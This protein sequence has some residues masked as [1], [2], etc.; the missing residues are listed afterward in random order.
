MKSRKLLSIIMSIVLVVGLTPLPAFAATDSYEAVG[1]SPDFVAQS[2]QQIEEQ[3]E[4]N[5]IEA[6]GATD[7]AAASA[8]DMKLDEPVSGTWGTCPWTIDTEGTLTIH[9]GTGENVPVVGYT[10]G[11]L[12]EA[13]WKKYAPYII[14]VVLKEESGQKVVLPEVCGSLFSWGTGTLGSES[15]NYTLK[16]VDLRGADF[17]GVKS[18]YE[19]F[20]CDEALETITFGADLNTQN[21]QNMERAFRCC[22]S[23]SAIDLSHFNTANVTN[24]YRMFQQCDLLTSLDL[25]GFNMTSA[26]KI[27]D[28]FGSCYALQTLKLS[29]QC[30]LKIDTKT[31]GLPDI[32]GSGDYTGQWQYEGGGYPLTPAQFMDQF[33]PTTKAGTWTW[34]VA[35]DNTRSGVWGTCP[36]NIDAQ[37]TLTVHPG[38]GADTEKCPWLAFKGL[39]KKVVLA[40]ESGNKVVLPANCSS[41]FAFGGNFNGKAYG[42]NVEEID[43]SGA[44]SSQVTNMSTMFGA[45]NSKLTSITFPATWDTSHVTNMAS[46]FMADSA[47][48]SIDLSR[49]DTSSVKDMGHMFSSCSNLTSLDLSGFN[50]SNVAD[51]NSMFFSCGALKSITLSNSWDTSHVTNM[52]S[53]FNFCHSLNSIDFSRFNTSSVTNMSYMLKDCDALTKLDLSNFDTSKVTNMSRLLAENDNLEEV[54]LSSFTFEA[55][56][57]PQGSSTDGFFLNSPKL[58]KLTF[59]DKF[60]LVA[61][62]S[63]SRD[64]NDGKGWEW[65]GPKGT[66]TTAALMEL[67]SADLAGTWVWTKTGEDPDPNAF[68]WGRDN[69]NFLNNSLNGDFR[70][71]T[72]RQQISGPYQDILKQNLTPSEYQVIFKGYYYGGYFYNAWL[73]DAWGGSCYGMS[74]TSLLAKAGILPYASYGEG[75]TA[76]AQL[77]RP[78]DNAQVESLIT[79]YQMLQVKDV[80]QNQYRSVKLRSHQENIQA[81]LSALGSSPLVLVCYRQ[82]NWGGHAVLAYGVET[83]SWTQGSRTYDARI[84]ICDP[85]ASTGHDDAFDIY[86]DTSTYAWDIP[87]YRLVSSANGAVF[88]YVGASTADINAGGYLNGGQAAASG[89]YIARLD[90]YNST[91]GDLAVTKVQREGDGYVEKAT[92]AGD[93]VEDLTF[94]MAGESDG[95]NGFDLR[96]AGSSY[97]VEKG[98]GTD[99]VALVMRYEDSLMTACLDGAGAV[100]FDPDGTVEVEGDGGFSVSVTSDEVTPTDWFAMSVSGT[101]DGGASIAKAEGGYVVQSGNLSGVKVVAN[102]KDEEVSLTFS[103]TKDEVLVHEVEAGT[104]NEALAVSVDSNGDGTFDE[105]VARS[106]DKMPV[107]MHRLYNPN[108]YEHF[109]TGDEAEFEHLVS[110]GWQDEKYGWTAP[111]YGDPVYRLYNPNNGGDHHY[112]LDPD[113]RDMLIAAGWQDE[114]IGWYSDSNKTVTVYREYNPNEVARNHN[115]TA[116]KAEHDYLVSLGW[117]DELIAWYGV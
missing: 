33:D 32:D 34:A 4:A 54:N 44:D 29:N 94:P 99:D 41:L 102:D 84:L 51:M 53:M 112:T 52:M 113:E 1:F 31:V 12:Y 88:N 68:T 69:W 45:W 78:S 101:A 65:V 38:T 39:V 74:S 60:Q 97:R 15:I 75:A 64:H 115:Y 56:P 19:L 104:A 46:M 80:I 17:S 67:P 116:D 49:F 87:A 43:L 7:M 61:S 77:S 76:L 105:V 70:Q 57:Y 10:Y 100:V 55:M 25:S 48:T 3:A 95:V 16:S 83:G 106:D 92:A 89:A 62:M 20:D 91:A 23:L 107:K 22:K 13:P 96:D 63:L 73:D 30:V 93:I 86:Y 110:L 5:D 117:R 108:S 59:G 18:M 14:N 82:N 35:T 98:A 114:E 9:P 26:T 72:Y 79:Y 47:L 28:M 27:D 36:W 66:L 109:Y 58:V 40:E 111:A 50:T 85:N 103:T 90:A 21:V 42:S 24:F 81:I 11:S 37:G 6:S 8:V 71:T 2:A